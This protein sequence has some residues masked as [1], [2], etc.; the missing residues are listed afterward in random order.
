LDKRTTRLMIWLGLA[1]ALLGGYLLFQQ[2]ATAKFV[3]G[4]FLLLVGLILILGDVMIKNLGVLIPGGVAVG[5]GGAWV[6][7]SL[8]GVP[9]VPAPSVFMLMMTVGFLLIYLLGWRRTGVWPLV[10]ALCVGAAG[11]LS[12][13]LYN[14]D[15][16]KL[17]EWII[18]WWPLT[19]VAAGVALILVGVL[20]SRGRKAQVQPEAQ[21]Q[22]IP[23]PQAQPVS[24]GEA[25]PAPQSD[26]DADAASAMG[27]AQDEEQTKAQPADTQD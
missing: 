26:V 12:L 1:L 14:L 13:L 8:G 23:A 21:A 4:T 27:A 17:T 5:L 19:L 2:L 15:M 20:P 7:G 25:Q 9:Y 10:V 24:E 6:V 11:L 22:N 18:R 3:G 16:W